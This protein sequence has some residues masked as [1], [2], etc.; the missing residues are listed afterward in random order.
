VLS[1][2]LGIAATSA[3]AG[4][5]EA[6]YT[7][8]YAG[9]ILVIMWGY[10]FIRL[11]FWYATLTGWV[12]VAGYQVVAIAYQHLLTAPM[13]M[14]VYVNNNFFFVTANILGMFAAYFIERYT[15][16]DFL[17][18]RAI[19]VEK[20]KSETLLQKEAE[21]KLRESEALFRSLIEISAE[22]IALLDQ[23][24]HYLYVSPAYERLSG[25]TQAE[26]LGQPFIPHIYPDDLPAVMDAL[27]TL[28]SGSDPIITVEQRF[29]RK[30]GAVRF[31]NSVAKL[32]P[33]GHLVAYVHYTTE[34][35]Q[36]EAQLRASE[37][38][39]RS[40]I[41]NASDGIAVT[42][43]EG[44]LAY[45]SPSYERILGW[46]ADELLDQPFLPL[47][48]PDD[49]PI[50][51]ENVGK[52]MT[53]PGYIGSTEIRVRHKD[54]S[55]RIIEGKGQLLPNGN[56]VSN[57][58]DVTKRRQL[59]DDLRR[60]NEDLEQRVAERTTQLEATFAERTRLAEIMEATTDLVAFATLDGQPL[61]L[62]Q[63]GRRILGLADEVEVT[64]L[65]FADLYPPEALTLFETV[66]LPTALAEGTWSSEVT[67]KRQDGHLIPV[68]LVGIIHR[69]P[70]GTPSHLSAIARDISEREQAEEALQT[71]LAESR[72][73]ATIIEAMPTKVFLPNYKFP[74]FELWR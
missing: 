24:G 61:Y 48:H 33:N 38:Y 14:E 5:T 46:T 55:W 35:R 11:R 27:T 56:I 39:F 4:P 32:L 12:I 57:T 62:N 25:Y 51:A 63:A 52:L 40:L 71:A 73:L 45:V 8:Y 67:V 15:R 36:L 10:T 74:V 31:F 47:I 42:D 7:T 3:V 16:L 70:D 20:T 34:R 18:R 22:G 6:A 53:I 41:E 28:V 66:G 9:L 44:K 23:E 29:I 30:D 2:G 60:L 64:S 58:R 26:L 13:G 72:R 19:E 65:T 43:P 37:E 49:V 59:E 68:S 54:G 50:A 17:Q 69:T 21:E 1:G